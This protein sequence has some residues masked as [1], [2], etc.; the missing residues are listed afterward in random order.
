MARL[1]YSFQNKYLLTV[2]VRRD[3][4]SLFGFSN[5]YATFPAVALGWVVSEERFF[6]PTWFNYLKLRA[7]WGSNGNRDIT[8]YA[9]LSR[10]G[11]GRSL[12]AD[13]GGVAS[14]ITTLLI[15]SMENRKLQ[16]EKTNAFNIGTDFSLFKNILS[17]TLEVYKTITTDVLVNRLLP[18]VT[19]FERVYAN[20]G[21][22]QNKGIEL[23]LNSRNISRSNFEWTSNL[24]FSLNRNKI[25][26]ITGEKSNVFDKAGNLIG[27]KEANDI[28]NN[29]FIGESKDVIWDYKIL[30]TWK[31]GQE[32]EAAV[33]DQ[34][35]GDFIIKD[36]GDGIL[37]ADDKEF[38]GYKTP[39]F[40]WVL[41]NSFQLFKN[42][43]ALFQ[44]I[45]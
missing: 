17:G 20:L 30:G 45:R 31:T 32:T 16:W 43:E 40:S 8:N 19:G 44:G 14:P 34:V 24:V 9:A 35:P 25:V 22:V 3:G 10:I 1:N 21:E 38:Q 29:W 42:L 39:R 37:T 11:N 36:D 33:W 27:Q 26:S 5:P 28:A 12:N 7:S 2:S 6:H 18:T 13:N 41:T 15:T 23:T 4:S